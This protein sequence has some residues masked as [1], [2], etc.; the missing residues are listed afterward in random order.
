MRLLF[1]RH[2]KALSRD[3]WNGDDLLR[4]LSE[5][6]RKKARDFFAKLPHIYP[7]DVIVSSKALRA[8]QTAQLLKEFYP[9]AKYFETSRLNPGATPLAYEA[10]IEKFRGYQNVAFVGHEP[11]ISLA[12]GNLI[13]CEEAHMKIKKASVTELVGDDI[14]EL[15][16]MIYPKLLKRVG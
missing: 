16:S 5:E 6:G 13:G 3:E 10:M 15:V 9:N 12:V 4:P 8:S 14:F 1:V 2:A 11:D 7:I